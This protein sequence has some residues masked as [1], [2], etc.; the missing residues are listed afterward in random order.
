MKPETKTCQNCKKDFVIEVDD[1]SFY[2]KIKV[3]PPTFCPECRMIR[4]MIW[5]NCRSLYKRPC[6]NCGKSI[7]SMYSEERNKIV[8][9]MDCWNSDKRDPSVLSR[10]YDFS[11]SFFEQFKVFR[12]EAPILFA[13]HTG[14]LVRS[15]FTNYSADNNYN[16]GFNL[17]ALD[18]AE[19]LGGEL[20]VNGDIE[21][22]A[23]TPWTGSSATLAVSTSM[24]RSGVYS[25][26]VSAAVAGSS[27]QQSITLEANT[28][29]KLKAYAYIPSATGPSGIELRINDGVRYLS[30][31]T[32]YVK[33]EWV[34]FDYYFFQDSTAGQLQFRSITTG[35][36]FFIDDVSIKKALRKPLRATAWEN[37]LPCYVSQRGSI[38]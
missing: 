19:R 6:G 25:L 36:T 32:N 16:G 23:T 22:G 3:P 1:F 12:E 27:V 8:Y 17:F 38:L 15:D 26:E 13:H 33:N 35:G 5:R 18:I 37:G 7:I 29:Y 24:V 11:R 2:E 30:S 4:R 21:T 14:T 20:S 9:C 31:G 34:E 28:W 10:D